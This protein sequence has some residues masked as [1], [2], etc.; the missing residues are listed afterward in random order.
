M[1]SKFSNWDTAVSL[2]YAAEQLVLAAQL[3]T[4]D[5]VPMHTAVITAYERYVPAILEHKK[6]L[7]FDVA[8]QLDEAFMDYRSA[9]NRSLDR[10]LIQHLRSRLLRVLAIVDHYLHDFNPEMLAA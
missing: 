3:L 5:M 1:P 7:P 6:W 4:S 8:V 10:S 2:A 9:R